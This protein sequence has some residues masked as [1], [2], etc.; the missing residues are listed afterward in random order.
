MTDDPRLGTTLA[1]RYRLDDLLGT[2]GMGRVYAAEHVLMR[3]KLAVKVLHRELTTV[4]EVVKRFEREA[5]AAAHIEHP[6]VAAAT[7]FGKLPDGSV[8]LVLEFVQGELLRDEIAKGPLPADRAL[9]IARQIASALAS[10][11][12]LEIVHRDLKPENVMLVKKG[13]N[14]DFVKVLDFGIAKV[15]I[16]EVGELARDG[17]PITRAGMVFGTPEYMAPEQALGQSVDGRADLY[18]LGTMLFEMLA[19]VRPYS[20]KSQVGILGQQLANPVPSFSVRA[21]GISIPHSVEQVVHRLLARDVDDR[22]QSANDVVAAIDELLRLT[23]PPDTRL[24]TQLGGSPR[25]MLGSYPGLDTDAKSGEIPLPSFADESDS[26]VLVRSELASG[27][28]A[29]EGALPGFD[30]GLD[31]IGPS[32]AVPTPLAKTS[33][34][35]GVELL[36]RLNRTPLLK[37]AVQFVEARRSSLPPP[38]G[39]AFKGVPGL[40]LLAGLALAAIGFFGVLLAL[41][42]SSLGDERPLPQAQSSAA[43]DARTS[44]STEGVIAPPVAPPEAAPP[45][46]LEQLRQAEA[47]GLP[48]LEALAKAHPDEGT[49]LLALAQG[50]VD[51]KQYAEAVN[52]VS[53]ALEVDPE[54]KISKKVASLLF[55]TSQSKSGRERT[56]QL[57]EGPMGSRG[58]DI[59]YDIAVHPDI[60]PQV[61]ARAEKYLASDAFERASSPE[62]NIAVALLQAD[63]CEQ[64][65]ALLLRAK[66][67]GDA[68]S[69]KHLDTLLKTD[70]CDGG[71]RD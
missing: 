35:K 17:Q 29:S 16:G 46:L 31:P 70:G 21:P 6:N 30:N 24:F 54:L 58:A 55:T 12:E 19:G 34:A 47:Q 37:G 13:N 39:N 23:A 11:H 10:A 41:L 22:Y 65:H 48:A 15:P 2:G 1:D 57:L 33:S 52:A 61:K 64:K 59:V 45:S 7:D 36:Q 4:P 67:V 3:K 43:P 32:G 5:M 28:S 44:T 8:F 27:E 18:A 60:K 42:V 25:E 53:A 40:A 71:K 69:L 38:I 26:G 66:N 68:R 49:V 62:L 63:R 14:S 51:A 9:R 20:S 56:F 50:R